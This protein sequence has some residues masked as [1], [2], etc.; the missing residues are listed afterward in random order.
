VNRL[1]TRWKQV[2]RQTNEGTKP[3]L[4]LPDSAVARALE[5]AQESI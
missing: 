3:L 4:N 5:T 1:M 2:K